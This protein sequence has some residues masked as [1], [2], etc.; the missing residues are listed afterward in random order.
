M[1][2]ITFSALSF[3]SLHFITKPLGCTYPSVSEV[4]E[5]DFLS[6]RAYDT[7]ETYLGLIGV[8]PEDEFISHFNDWEDQEQTCI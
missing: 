4:D 3:L 8:D 5:H 1:N 2:K 7:H 6:V